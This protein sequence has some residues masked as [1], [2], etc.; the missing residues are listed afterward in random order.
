MLMVKGTLKNGFEYEVDLDKMRS[1]RFIDAL[2]ELEENPLAMSKIVLMAFGS[3]QREKLY[4]HR[5][6]R[7]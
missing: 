6:N 4:T 7:R 3:D 5:K 1:M 2:A